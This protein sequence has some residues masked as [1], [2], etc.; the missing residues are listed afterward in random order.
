MYLSL[1]QR[2]PVMGLLQELDKVGS[3]GNDRKVVQPWVGRVIVRLDLLH[4]DRLLDSWHLINL[5]TIVQ[6]G[7]CTSHIA[8]IGLEVNRV[9]L[10]K[11]QQ[12]HKETNIG[13]GKLVPRNKSGC[14]EYLVDPVER[15][16]ELGNGDIIGC[17][18]LC[19]S[20]TINPIVLSK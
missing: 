18:R 19:K 15:L 11:A 6:N 12:G 14:L 10:V 3:A 5:S 20:A 4:I 9:D 7:R 1:A 16:G 2:I 17:L 8:R 13:F